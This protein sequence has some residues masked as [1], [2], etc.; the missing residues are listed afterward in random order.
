MRKIC[1][2]SMCALLLCGCGRSYE[3]AE[4]TKKDF[5]YGYF[6]QIKS[7]ETE[8]N[9]YFY[10]LYANDTKV[11]YLAINGYRRSG[12]TPLYNADGSLQIYNGE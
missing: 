7:W 12:I 4:T 5:D 1:L 11:M 10:I 6:T 3:E 9:G 2:L 8:D